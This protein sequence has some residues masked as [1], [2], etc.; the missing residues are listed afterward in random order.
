MCVCVRVYIH[1]IF[2]IT[3]SITHSIMYVCVCVFSVSNMSCVN[4]FGPR[5]NS[6][7]DLH[8]WSFFACGSGDSVGVISSSQS[9]PLI[10]FVQS[11]PRSH[12]SNRNV[13]LAEGVFLYF[14]LATAGDA[15]VTGRPSVTLNIKTLS[16]S[17]AK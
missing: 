10:S 13:C 14:T 11:H 15:L 7:N 12:L 3:H 5:V 2:L 4:A 16:I 1:V 9:H 8:F 6:L 17:W